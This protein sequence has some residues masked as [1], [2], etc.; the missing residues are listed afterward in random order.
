MLG[1]ADA[2]RLLIVWCELRQSFRHFRTERML[3]ADVL[4]E[5]NGLRKG[6]LRRLWQH[7]RE[8]ERN[9]VDRR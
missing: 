2:S 5:P 4:E 6:E 8:M 9:C 1:F 7:W 3:G